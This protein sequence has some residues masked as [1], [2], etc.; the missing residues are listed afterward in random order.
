MPFFFLA[1]FL[2][3]LYASPAF[4]FPVLAVLHPAQVA[5]I[6]AMTVLIMQKRV[7][8][9]NWRFVR[10]E[11]TLLLIFLVGV[12]LSCF[13]AYWPKLAVETTMTLLKIGVIYFAIVNLVDNG[14]RMRTAIMALLAGALFPAIGTVY[15]YAT[16]NFCNCFE[17]HRASWIGAYA[18]PNDL[19]YALVVLIPLA[20]QMSR[21]THWVWKPV[22]WG[23]VAIYFAAIFAT[24]SRGGLVGAGA[25]L[26][27]MGLRQSGIGSKVATATI[28]IGVLVYALFYW[29]RSEG[30]QDISKDFTAHQR[31]ETIKAGLRMF[32]D[33]PLLG[34]GI[35]CSVVAWPFYAP[36]DIDFRTSLII[37][38]TAVQALSEVGLLGFVPFVLFIGA[39]WIHVRRVMK[40]AE[41]GGE[42]RKLAVA[43]EASLCG[44]VVC[45]LFG[46]YVA[47]WFPYIIVGLISALV[48]LTK[49]K[50]ELDEIDA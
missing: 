23:V 27:L 44:F 1:S 47:S 25:V 6:G 41:I 39:G 21:I 32:V 35:G 20:F 5:G 19:A 14:R 45:G 2:F 12:A 40:S 50:R 4:L 7:W 38:N 3:M 31:V 34:V 49:G 37:H 42:A 18:N 48:C 24:H 15:N 11:G 8:T 17:G 33:Y 22:F 46:G 28:L 43:L 29:S 36:P 26:L 9:E 30:F 10:P 13:G 16:G